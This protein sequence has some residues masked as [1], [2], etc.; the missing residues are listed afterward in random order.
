M[1][2]RISDYTKESAS[3]SSKLPNGGTKKSCK[4]VLKILAQADF[5]VL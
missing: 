4:N 3:F 1:A 5:K 2:Q